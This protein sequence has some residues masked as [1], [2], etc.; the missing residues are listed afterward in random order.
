MFTNSWF[1]IRRVG[2]RLISRAGICG[3]MGCWGL[4]PCIDEVGQSKVFLLDVE[5]DKMSHAEGIDGVTRMYMRNGIIHQ[6]GVEKV[7]LSTTE[8]HI[9]NALRAYG[10][11]ISLDARNLVLLKPGGRSKEFR[12]ESA[13]QWPLNNGKLFYS[14]AING[15]YIQAIEEEMQKFPF[16]HVDIL[17][18]LA[19]VYDLI[20]AFRFVDYRDEDIYQYVPQDDYHGVSMV[21]GY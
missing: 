6:L 10:R 5:A 19:Y 2:M 18:M 9:A 21:T 16:Y 11:R 13:L 20:K 15:R 8:I 3:L 12:V 4:S 14:T 7:G 1:W 17:D